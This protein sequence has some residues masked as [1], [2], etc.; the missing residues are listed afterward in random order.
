MNITAY[1]PLLFAVMIVVFGQNNSSNIETDLSEPMIESQPESYRGG[2]DGYRG[3]YGRPPYG[4]TGNRGGWTGN[5][6]GWNTGYDP[7]RGRPY[8]GPSPGF[9]VGSI[10]NRILG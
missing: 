5:R 2:Y 3:G 4:W 10:V 9:I 7:Y 8:G 6:G 1:L